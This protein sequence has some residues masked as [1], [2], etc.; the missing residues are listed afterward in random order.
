MAF[1]SRNRPGSIRQDEVVKCD[2][3]S[4]I[5]PIYHVR[6]CTECVSWQLSLRV[7]TESTSWMRCGVILYR[8]VIYGI[9]P[10]CFGE[11]GRHRTNN[12]R[13][14]FSVSGVK[15][16]VVPPDRP[17]RARA[18]TQEREIHL[19]SQSRRHLTLVRHSWLKWTQ[20]T[21]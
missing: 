20:A 7:T 9:T 8:Y 1:R 17:A 15:I 4:A 11:T 2:R 18:R 6:T 5:T 3:N 14:V 10:A 19:T 12:N 16:Q 13:A 21:N